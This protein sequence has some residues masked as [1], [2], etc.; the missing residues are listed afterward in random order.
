MIRRAAL[1]LQP[2]WKSDQDG[3]AHSFGPEKEEEGSNFKCAVNYTRAD[4]RARAAGRKRSP[5]ATTFIL[6]SAKNKDR[7]EILPPPPLPPHSFPCPPEKR[8]ASLAAP[9]DAC[10]EFG[11]KERASERERRNVEHCALSPLHPPRTPSAARV[12]Q[13]CRATPFGKTPRDN[14]PARSVLQGSLGSQEARFFIQ[15]GST[16][17]LRPDWKDLSLVT[18][19]NKEFLD[20]L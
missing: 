13:S 1:S 20:T 4:G 17:A 19:G 6:H 18:W 2:S 9:V 7:G 15:I 11:Q 8:L 12:S 10:L 3:R 16:K 14:E 5:R